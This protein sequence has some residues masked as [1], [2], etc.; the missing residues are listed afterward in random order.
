MRCE[1][2]GTICCACIVNLVVIIVVIG[3]VIV[4]FSRNL[5]GDRVVPIPI[6]EMTRIPVVT[7]VVVAGPVTVKAYENIPSPV[8]GII[9]VYPVGAAPVVVYPKAIL[10]LN[11]TVQQPVVAVPIYMGV[12]VVIAMVAVLVTPVVRSGVVVN[13]N[14]VISCRSARSSFPMAA[15][16]TAFGDP[17]ITMTARRSPVNCCKFAALASDRFDLLS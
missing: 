11:D 1:V 3:I 8:V 16:I 9:V 10:R 13:Y 12:S 4:S 17:Y 15:G 7:P 6:I 14:C 5:S 2:A